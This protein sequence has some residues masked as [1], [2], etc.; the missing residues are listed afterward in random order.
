MKL[1]RSNPSVTIKRL[2]IQ[3]YCNY[4]DAQLSNLASGNRISFILCSIIVLTGVIT[5]GIPLLS[6]MML[7]AFLGIILPNHPF[8]YIYNFGIRKLIG[9]PK[10]PPR[11]KQIKFA[12][13]IATVWLAGT[14]TL[15]YIGFFLA[16]YIFG[17]ILFL[18]AFTVSTTDI[19][20]PSLLYN[21]MYK[22]KV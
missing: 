6:I 20:I 7:I 9:R 21:F 18:M 5:A 11:S 10:L 8:D 22:I 2:R 13:T 4:S 15:F 17:G 1:K 12:C 3:G 14:I 16:G 19:C